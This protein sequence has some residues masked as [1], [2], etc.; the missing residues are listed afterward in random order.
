MKITNLPNGYRTDEQ[1]K[2]RFNDLCIYFKDNKNQ[3]YIALDGYYLSLKYNSKSSGLRWFHCDKYIVEV[4][5]DNILGGPSKNISPWILLSN[6]EDAILL[7][8]LTE[9]KALLELEAQ[10]KQ[11]LTKGA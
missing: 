5:I 4:V 9:E 1:K 3:K 10:S 7:M 11:L 6:F 2:K 8:V